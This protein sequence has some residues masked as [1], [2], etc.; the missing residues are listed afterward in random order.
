MQYTQKYIIKIYQLDQLILV[1]TN[2]WLLEGYHRKLCSFKG[3]C[4]RCF[5]SLQLAVGKG[6]DPFTTSH[7]SCRET[8]FLQY[9][10][11]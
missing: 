8:V 6:E 11:N 2:I 3:N 1:E 10:S 5:I 9:L 7:F 4:E